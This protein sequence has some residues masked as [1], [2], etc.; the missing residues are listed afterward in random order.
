MVVGYHLQFGEGY[1][2]PAEQATQIFRRSYLLVDL[3]FVLSGF[4]ISYVN[5]AER[6][7]PVSRAEVSSFLRARIA[8]LYPLHL[9][10]LSYFIL[11]R[12]LIT[13]LQL[14]HH[15]GTDFWN[16]HSFVSFATQ[17]VLLN[18]WFPKH[19]VW[20][21]PSWSI[22]AEFFIYALFPV[23]V[24]L[25]VRAGAACKAGLLLLSLAFFTYI[26]STTGSLDIV[27]GLA[28]ARCAAGFFLGMLV[29]FYRNSIDR[30]PTII[31]SIL[32][33]G[34]TA[35]ICLVLAKPFADPMIIPA[36]VILVGSTWTDR[37]LLSR[38]LSVRPL[39][40]LGDLSYSVYLNHVCLMAI[41][42]FFWSRTVPHVLGEGAANRIMWIIFTYAVV[43]A[44]SH[45]TYNRVERPAR[46][47]L[48]QR[49]LGRRAPAIAT[50]PAA[51]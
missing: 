15:A 29:Y 10:C 25:H 27:V 26:F 30:L 34:A 51:P 22:S 31:L 37:G 24:N 38:L 9:F 6:N 47:W 12:V 33:L 8:R 1:R 42:G 41:L 2:L 23:V 7:R 18:A 45:L 49:W 20:N 16:P 32:Q 36:F 46:Q 3:F 19:P 40:W 13:I 44:V 5:D 50:S 21:I 43:I 39:M 48:A 14:A 35:A 11:A 28:P 17:L 4:I